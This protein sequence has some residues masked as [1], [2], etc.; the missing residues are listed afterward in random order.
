MKILITENEELAS[1]KAASLLKQAVVE[2]PNA[3]LGLATGGTMLSVYERLIGMYRLGGFSFEN[4]MSFNLDEYVGVAEEHHASYRHYMNSNL[5]DHID[6]QIKNTHLPNGNELNVEQNAKKYEKKIQGSSGIDLILLGIG[7]N[8]HIGFNEP[9]SSLAS[10]TRV[11]TL[12]Q[13]TRNQNLKYFDK[14]EDVPK[15]AVTMGLQTILD[16]KK[17]LLVAT[18]AAKAQAVAKMVEGGVSAS[19]PAS[20]LQHHEKTTIIIDKA[21]ASKLKLLDYYENVHPNGEEVYF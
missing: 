9:T 12:T 7:K 19:C 3:I 11:K 2:K 8:G 14:I 6:I 1:Q 17:C 10:R 18:G 5:F 21:A 13:S 20:I 16:A 4:I 15:Y